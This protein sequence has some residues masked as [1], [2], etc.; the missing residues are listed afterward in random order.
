[1]ARIPNGSGL[2][3]RA[4]INSQNADYDDLGQNMDLQYYH[5][6]NVLQI[7]YG[8]EGETWE[9]GK[10][11]GTS[12]GIA[13]PDTVHFKTGAQGIKCTATTAN[14]G[15]RLVK[16]LDLTEFNDTVSNS[17]DVDYI[18]MVLYIDTSDL[19]NLRDPGI[20][21]IFAGDGFGT[22]QNFFRYLIPKSVLSAGWNYLKIAKSSF[23]ISGTPDWGAIQGLSFYLAL[24]DPIAPVN[25]TVDNIQ[26]IRKDIAAGNPNPFQREVDGR[27][28]P[29]LRVVS[30]EWYL[31]ME[32]G[33]VIMQNLWDT[34]DD[35]GVGTIPASLV[36][37]VPFTDFEAFLSLGDITDTGYLEWE[38]DQ[39]NRVRCSISGGMLEVFSEVGGA[40]A[41]LG[42]TPI[43]V[44]ADGRVMVAMEK[45][46]KSFTVRYIH[47]DLVDRPVMVTA[48]VDAF[49]N[50]AGYVALGERA[51]LARRIYFYDFGISRVKFSLKAYEAQVARLALKAS[52]AM[53]ANEANHATASITSNTALWN[54]PRMIAQ[55]PWL[56]KQIYP[57]LTVTLNTGEN[58]CYCLFYDGKYIYAI[59]NQTPVTVIQ[60]DINLNRLN[61]ISLP[62][63]TTATNYAFT[64]CA[65]SDGTYL[66]VAVRG[67]PQGVV[68]K[69]RPVDLSIVGQFTATSGDADFCALVYTGQYLF[70]SGSNGAASG[71]LGKLVRI[72]PETM[73]QMGATVTFG[74]GEGLAASLLWDGYYVYVA[75]VDTPGKVF[76][77]D[78]AT[79]TRTSALTLATGE[80]PIYSMNFD[81]Q[82]IYCTIGTSPGRLARVTTILTEVTPT[83][84]WATGVNT[85][86]KVITDGYWLYI[87]F[88]GSGHIARYSTG[89]ASGP[90]M[91]PNGTEPIGGMTTD[92]LNLFW[93]TNTAPAKIYR[94]DLR[95]G[96]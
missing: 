83:P 18:C 56:A 92:G 65:T 26:M 43:P 75:T 35:T 67:I 72:D 48:N 54:E 7:A 34:P 25:F 71:A 76:K 29:A 42:Q 27:W 78:P 44:A 41:L 32:S 53:N 64:N 16:N 13:T 87:G 95:A 80:G 49:G 66:Y 68:Y 52:E 38:I 86:V 63:V 89:N 57:R 14:G 23:V 15:I 91:N 4:K 31:G 59:L 39:A 8:G 82:I 96:L 70:V 5:C 3:V 84:T 12:S 79:I 88:L 11:D 90:T 33:A 58:N 77:Y 50:R 45:N 2:E 17:I 60:F 74:T 9:N 37:T 20:G 22:Y 46:G 21:L 24:E 51:N 1:M 28:V 93:G 62:V 47:D 85:P 40:S 73:T 69:I 81:G 55:F 36:H 94:R 30:G 10:W 6:R 61:A 19:T